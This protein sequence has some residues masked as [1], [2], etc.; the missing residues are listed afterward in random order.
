VSDGQLDLF[1]GSGVP[2]AHPAPP[3]ARPAQAAPAELSDAALLA[4]IPGSGIAD[5]PSLVAEA[6]RRRLAAAIPILE[7]Y[8]RRFAGFGTQH[9]LPEQIA[10]LDALAA[11]GG[12]DAAAAVA[13]II[14][15]GWVQGPT[16]VSAVAAAARLGSRLPADTVL[17]LLRHADP[18]ARADACRLARETPD[19][20]T[21]LTDLLG[22]LHR[23]VSIEAAC[24][25]GRMNRPDA[26]LW[27]KQAL[28]EAPSLPV[29][30]AVPLVADEECMVLLGRIAG[31][32]P[33]LAA[34]AR[35]ALAAIEHPVAGRILRRLQD[36]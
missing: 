30:E 18:A 25:L 34:A 15:R 32:S 36:G 11:I 13:R 35:D 2:A 27:L 31:T 7:D 17:A 33:E 24:A 28:R 26:V 16:L 14:G 21:T 1:S 12:A 4:A 5:G 9:P 8:C 10:A 19:I 20:V 23:D 6:G 29:I 22:D 3:V